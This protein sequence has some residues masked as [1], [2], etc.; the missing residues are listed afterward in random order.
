MPSFDG[1]ES[2]PESKQSQFSSS[3]NSTTS[4]TST[5]AGNNTN[6]QQDGTTTSPSVKLK[7]QM[8]FESPT[9]WSGGGARVIESTTP[10]DNSVLSDGQT[11]QENGQWDSTI[12]KAGLGK[13]G[14]VINK[15]VSDNDGLKRELKIERL[16]AEEA[17]QASKLVEDKMERIVSDYESRLLESN[18]TKTLLARKERQVETLSTTV[19]AEKEKTRAALNRER[20][21]KEELDVVRSDSKTKVE[22]ATTF[23]QLMEGRYN[24]ISSHWQ[25]QGEEVKQAVSTMGTKISI[26]TKERKQDDEKI[27]R[28]RDLC[29]QQ[30]SNI[31][32]LIREKDEIAAKFEQYKQAQE[33]DLRDIKTKGRQRDEEQDK[34]L[35]DSKEALDK[36]RWALNVKTNVKGAG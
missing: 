32:K 15:L 31:Q 21:W 19:E 2:S 8:S 10:V 5:M 24:A 6:Q 29:N 35:A 4:A 26:I 23:A 22:E 25:D 16:R 1:F 13:T 18:V 34:L 20:T 7:S 33:D 30:D 3:I 12:G 36:L 17:W 11:E 28:L 27:Q 14:R 9:K